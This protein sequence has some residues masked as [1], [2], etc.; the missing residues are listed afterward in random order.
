M[1]EHRGVS[2]EELKQ[3]AVVAVAVLLGLGLLAAWS[4]LIPGVTAWEN[5]V[6]AAIGSLRVT[7]PVA[8][9][10]AA[11][12]AVR[13]H[14]AARGTPLTPWRSLRTPLAVVVVVVVAFCATVL[15]LT[16]RAALGEAAG[17]LLPSG[18][19]VGASGLVLYVVL[20]WI[21]GWL[22]PWAITPLLTGI[23]CYALFTWLAERPTWAVRLAPVTREPYD[24]FGELNSGAF[25]DQTIWLLCLGATLLLGW[26]AILT[27]QVAV[28]AVA[29]LPLL[30]AVTGLARL[31]SGWSSVEAAERMADRTTYRCQEWPIMVCVHPAMGSG[32]TE[33]ATVFT[34]VAARLAGTAGAFSRVE[35]HPRGVTPP[36]GVVAVHIDDLR[37]GF[38]KRAVAEFVAGLAPP[39]REPAE[40]YRRIVTAW[41]SGDPLPIGPLPQHAAAAAWFSGLAEVQRRDWL[42]MFYADFTSCRLT[43]AHFGVGAPLP[44]V[45]PGRS[46]E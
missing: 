22:V 27:R 16:L 42:R 29:L 31:Q 39:C 44:D 13:G 11:W 43:Q 24:L 2:R 17:R 35:Q 32:L 37:P 18:L 19:A 28:L 30:G 9:A 41:L 3:S 21:V 38:A 8:A 1:R 23:G 7:G 15:V 46:G 45:R 5:I 6:V 34:T 4:V 36:A 12:V 26:S 14:R 33:L 25:L 40:G 10:F 20:G